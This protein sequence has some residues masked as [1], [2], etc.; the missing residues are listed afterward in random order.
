MSMSLNSFFCG[1][2]FALDSSGF[3]NLFLKAKQ[4]KVLETLLLGRNTV[5]VLP[6]GYGKSV[7]FQLLPYLFDYKNSTNDSIVLVIA[8]LDAL[9]EDQIQSM[10]SRGIKAGILKTFPKKAVNMHEHSDDENDMKETHSIDKEEFESIKSGN[11][12]LLYS[13]PEG[14]IYRV[15]KEESYF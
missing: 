12:R 3:R 13:H 11:I 1:I 6:T 15:R 2:R 4:L 9:I 14:F 10:K 8:P 7:I 5:G